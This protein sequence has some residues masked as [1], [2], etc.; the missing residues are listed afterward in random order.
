MAKVLGIL[1]IVLGIWA[2]SEIYTKGASHAF[3]GALVALGF[4]DRAPDSADPQSLGQRSG[5]KV[6]RAHAEADAR[7]DRMLAE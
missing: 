4:E 5:D 6:G 7:R 2:G 3:G 1:L